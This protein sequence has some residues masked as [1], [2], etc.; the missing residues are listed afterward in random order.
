MIPNLHSSFKC[1]TI[2]WLN[3]WKIPSLHVGKGINTVFPPG[4]CVE[5]FIAASPFAVLSQLLIMQ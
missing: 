3:T 1:Y 2:A 5:V 4:L